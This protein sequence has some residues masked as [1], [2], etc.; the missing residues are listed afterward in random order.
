LALLLIILGAVAL[1]GLS[2]YLIWIQPTLPNAIP[3]GF[4]ASGRSASLGSPARLLLLPA[5]G[6]LAWVLDFLLGLF[7]FERSDRAA[8]LTLWLVGVVLVVGLWV[9]SLNLLAA[10]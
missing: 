6:A 7:A 5:A 9:G 2:V 10:S 4:D 8:S 1:L 3:F